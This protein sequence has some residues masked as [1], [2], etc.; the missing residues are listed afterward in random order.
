MSE[1]PADYNVDPVVA[2]PGEISLSELSHLT[3][4]QAGVG[5][6]SPTADVLGETGFSKHVLGGEDARHRIEVG[7]VVY[8]IHT[9]LI[10][11]KDH[12]AYIEFEDKFVVL[13]ETKL[14]IKNAKDRLKLLG[15][16]GLA[17]LCASTNMGTVRVQ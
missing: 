11:A 4:Q 13:G 5:Y 12:S 9:G 10:T 14:Q 3:S 15:P 2:S 1:Y 6:R 8:Q 7:G 16:D 17:K